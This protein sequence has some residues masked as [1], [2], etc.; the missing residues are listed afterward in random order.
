LIEMRNEE[1]EL[2]AKGIF[3]G[4]IRNAVKKIKQNG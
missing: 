2:V 1:A 3:S 4:I